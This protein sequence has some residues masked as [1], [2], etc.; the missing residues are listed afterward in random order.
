MNYK[1]TILKFKNIQWQPA[2]IKQSRDGKIDVNIHV[3]ITDLIEMQAKQSFLMGIKEYERFIVT[4]PNDATVEQ[5]NEF[6]SLQYKAWGFDVSV[7]SPPAADT[8]E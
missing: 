7:K 1:D 3:P 5:A 8:G 4:V 6:I 2:K